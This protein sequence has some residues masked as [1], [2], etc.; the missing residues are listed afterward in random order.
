M[1]W[2]MEQWGDPMGVRVLG[3]VSVFV[4]AMDVP[5]T[6]AERNLVALLAVAGD[7]GLSNERLA[8]ELWPDEMPPSWAAS[9]RN[10]ISRLNRKVRDFGG[11]SDGIITARSSVRRLLVADRRHV[12]LWRLLDGVKEGDIDEIALIAGAPFPDC[13]I[14]PSLRA[15]FDTIQAARL[16]LLRRWAVEGRGRSQGELAEL[17]NLARSDP[18]D[19]ALALAV[20]SVHVAA[21]R[22]DAARR[23]ADELAAELSSWGVA[24]S[25]ELDAVSNDARSSEPAPS[26]SV[27]KEGR[28]AGIG[29][30]GPTS[31]GGS[32]VLRA[33]ALGR[34]TAASMVGRDAVF[35]D[36]VRRARRRPT[37][38]LLDGRSGVG[39]TRLAA[40]VASRL[41]E[42]GF[43]TVYLSGDRRSFG[44]LQAFLGGFRGLAPV[45]AQ[46]LAELNREDVKAACRLAVVDHIETVYGGRPV[47]LLVDDAQWLDEQSQGLLL[48][49]GRVGL[50]QGLTLLVTGRTVDPAT[51]WENWIED[52]VR[53]GLE[54][55]T[56]AGLDRGAVVEMVDRRLPGLDR[57]EVAAL[58]ER[59]LHQSDGVPEV[60]TW[61]LGRLDPELPARSQLDVVGTGYDAIVGTCDPEVQRFGAAAAVVG[62]RFGLKDV[63][64]LA[65]PMA[66]GA[67]QRLAA[68]LVASTLVEE[69]TEPEEYRFVHALAA[70]A[71]ARTVSESDAA[72]LHARAF[73][74]ATDP[75]RQASHVAPAGEL[76]DD[77]T[78]ASVMVDAARLSFAEGNFL[79]TEAYY[80]D[81]IERA[82]DL[83]TFDDRLHRLEAAE[84][85]GRRVSPWRQELVNEALRVGD[86]PGALAAAMSGLP[87]AEPFEGDVE[88]VA[89]L[90]LIDVENLP[91]A[92]GIL[93]RLALAR[94]HLL[95]G[96]ADPAR[97]LVEEAASAATTADERVAVWLGRWPLR[98]IGTAIVAGEEPPSTEGLIDRHLGHRVELAEVISTVAAGGSVSGYPRIV[99]YVDEMTRTGSAQLRWFALMLQ[100]TAL[101]DQ[102]RADEAR[103]VARA[104]HQ[105]GLRAGLRAAAG[106]NETQGMVRL[107]HD[108]QVGDLYPGM[109][110]AVPAH[111]RQNL[112]Y[113]A[114]GVVARFARGRDIGDRTLVDDAV[115]RLPFVVEMARRSVFDATIA[116]L[117]IDVFAA[118]DHADS[119]RWA[120]D[121]LAARSGSHVLV[122]S[123]IANLGPADALV[124]LVTDDLAERLALLERTVAD[125]DADQ[126]PLW[127]VVGRLR[128]AEHVGVDTDAGQRWVAEAA[129]RASSPWLRRLLDRRVTSLRRVGERSGPDR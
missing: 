72:E 5:L 28:P 50:H 123:G 7:D 102:G 76:I 9:V 12:D 45:V 129:G 116:G 86:H 31:G 118:S 55:V 29:N 68:A 2:N 70:E 75:R 21:G 33:A 57:R 121:R 107:L 90:R 91:V 77:R 125:A 54:R 126:L 100:A 83:V 99:R 52:L 60:V 113:E 51:R 30:S 44:T 122:A 41:S 20:I 65:A 73:G 79:D 26:G 47:C 34:L 32:P 67:A 97:A 120:L 58:A 53:I 1:W 84:R 92:D 103:L 114:V 13:E 6:P 38:F 88:R 10:A 66:P 89:V 46:H 27:A 124:A 64:A 105:L 111:L 110:D 117:L 15:G 40:G 106:T 98:G 104:A 8:D 74:S 62:L 94:Q 80:N 85:L 128:V 39:K 127:Q 115:Q 18:M 11:P 48:A 25:P 109:G 16:D 42:A 59:A 43:H 36:L 81:A 78:A 24:I 4:A 22:T 95:L 23:L 61:L 19:Q 101:V 3:T 69:L 35:A 82:A 17:R 63:E 108:G 37:G 87:D 119:R 96:Q 112:I 49:L 71:F 14:S 93:W 56:V